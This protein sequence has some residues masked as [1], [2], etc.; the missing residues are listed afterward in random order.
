MTINPILVIGATGQHGNTGGSLVRRLRDEGYPVRVLARTLSERT[1]RL[2]DL[3]AEVVVGDLTD[4]RSLLPALAD[5][6]LAYFTYP[7][8][9]G[10]VSAAANYASA[11]RE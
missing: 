5:V 1:D 7:I 10:V 3:G 2:A 9:A 4:R 11:V 6:D 8:A